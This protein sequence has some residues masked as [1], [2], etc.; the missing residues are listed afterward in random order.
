MAYYQ[1]NG[2]GNYGTAVVGTVDASNNSISFGTPVVFESAHTA[3]YDTIACE[4]DANA[5][6]VLIS[7]LDADNSKYGTAIVGTVSGTSIS[8]GSAVVY[9]QKQRILIR[10]MTTTRKKYLL[11]TETR[12]T[13]LTEPGL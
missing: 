1:D 3:Q 11:F 6:K 7:Y 13:A 12:E 2:N 9:Q 10:L 4:Y 5:Q 8:F